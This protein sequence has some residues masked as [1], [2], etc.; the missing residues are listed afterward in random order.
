MQTDPTARHSLIGPFQ[1]ACYLVHAVVGHRL[2]RGPAPSRGVRPP[3]P[4]GHRRRLQSGRCRDP[5]GPDT[6]PAGDRPARWLLVE[7]RGHPKT[8]GQ[9]R[10]R[11]AARW[12]R[13]LTGPSAAGSTDLCRPGCRCSWPRCLRWRPPELEPGHLPI[14]PVGVRA[15]VHQQPAGQAERERDQ[16]YEVGREPQGALLDGVLDRVGGRGHPRRARAVGTGRSRSRGVLVLTVAATTGALLSMAGGRPGATTCAER[17][18]GWLLGGRGR[19][20]GH[21]GAVAWPTGR[22]P[23]PSACSRRGRVEL[24]GQAG[25]CLRGC[26]CPAP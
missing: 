1:R 9:S 6:A 23:P 18:L 4:G 19:N 2:R 13:T 25:R 16:R 5:P 12:A 21:L 3:A 26:A 10:R 17:A 7:G 15:R 22:F 11:C 20:H 14:D 24:A 8:R